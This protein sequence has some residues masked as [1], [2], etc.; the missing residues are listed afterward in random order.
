M[1]KVIHLSNGLPVIFIK[2]EGARLAYLNVCFNVGSKDET[3]T[4]A[5]LAHA[6]EHFVFVGSEHY[7]QEEINSLPAQFGSTIDAA[8]DTDF[9]S[10]GFK[11]LKEHFVPMLDI[12]GDILLHP[13]FPSA[14]IK[15]EIKVIKAEM[16]ISEENSDDE[17]LECNL[18]ACFGI[19]KRKSRVFGSQKALDSFN[20]D[21]ARA[22]W[23]KYYTASNCVVCLYADKESY[24]KNIENVLGKMRVNTLPARPSHCFRGKSYR[25]SGLSSGVEINLMFEANSPIS[26]SDELL[27]VV[28]G[29]NY[30]SRLYQALRYE[31]ALI[32]SVSADIDSYTCGNMFYISAEC[33]PKDLSMVVSGICRIITSVRSNLVEKTELDIAKEVAKTSLWAS[34]ECPEDLVID[35]SEDF[36]LHRF[37]AMEEKLEQIEAVTPENIKASAE[38]IF[39]QRPS[40]GVIGDVGSSPTYSDVMTWLKLNP[41]Q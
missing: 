33:R 18:H 15:K 24:L 16:A 25:A 5:G 34:F 41:P 40:Y 19:D 17:R 28:L 1:T 39:S 38:R 27:S 20:S 29:G 9:T 14:L 10:F 11:V 23:E 26:V 6:V 12:L 30:N 4:E 8:T 36:L 32:Y 31:R 22:F 3:V 7:T 2:N 37:T 21:R 35:T 13:S